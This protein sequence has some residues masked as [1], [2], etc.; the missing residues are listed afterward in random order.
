MVIVILV[1]LALVAGTVWLTKEI[2]VWD[3]PD[4]T[5]EIYEGVKYQIKPFAEDLKE[6]YCSK[7]CGTNKPTKPWRESFVDAWNDSIKE[8]F[9]T[10]NRLPKY[11][12]RFTDDV[13]KTIN[14]LFNGNSMK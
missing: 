7:Y 5:A 14:Q 9:L 3:G 12:Y 1:K 8:G 11:C 13:Q 6:R 4:T 10:A 2:G